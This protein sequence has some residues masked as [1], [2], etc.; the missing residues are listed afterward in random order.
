MVF[1]ITI[2]FSYNVEHLNANKDK[3]SLISSISYL[4]KFLILLGGLSNIF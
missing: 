1:L 2:F 3:L 4:V